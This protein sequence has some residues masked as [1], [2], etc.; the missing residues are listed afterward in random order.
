MAV[1][2]QYLYATFHDPGSSGVYFAISQDGRK[3]ETLNGGQPWLAPSHPGELMRDPFISRGP[4]GEFH[5]VWTWEWRVQSIGYAHSR[6]LIH[7]SEQKE[8][9][10]MAKVEGTKNTW[11]P[12]IY[13]DAAKKQ[14]LIIWSSVVEGKYDGNRIY[15]SLTA[16]WEHFTPPSIFFDPGYEVIDATILQTGSQFHLVFKDE[17]KEPLKKFIQI[18]SGPTLEGPWSGI[19]EPFTEAWTE[20]PSIVRLRGEYVVYYDHYRDPKRMEAVQSRDL[21]HWSPMEVAFPEGSRHGTFLKITKEEAER[22]Q[23]GPK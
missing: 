13:W 8:I 3:W 11:A 20:G 16:D 12:E 23:N 9:P 7:W 19:S 22:L 4:D 18:A 1:R 14:W 17:R 5:M 6:D 2:G 15:S 21:K 10:L